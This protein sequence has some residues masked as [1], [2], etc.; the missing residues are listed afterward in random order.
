MLHIT[1]YAAV[2]VHDDG[3]VFLICFPDNEQGC[4]RRAS[5]RILRQASQMRFVAFAGVV[6]QP[7]L[8][9]TTGSQMKH[10]VL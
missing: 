8:F 2:R 5:E 7:R 4:G 6:D 1:V 3:S 9:S 10:F